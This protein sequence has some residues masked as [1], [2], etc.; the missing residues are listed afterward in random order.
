MFVIEQVVEEKDYSINERLKDVGQFRIQGPGCRFDVRCA[1]NFPEFNKLFIGVGSQVQIYDTDK[2]SVSWLSEPIAL[3]LKPKPVKDNKDNGNVT[4][5]SGRVRADLEPTNIEALDVAYM[6]SK[7]ILFVLRTDLCIEFHSFIS[8]AQFSS[9]TVASCGHW[10]FKQP[11]SKLLIRDVPHMTTRLFMLGNSNKI[12][13]WLIKVSE[14]SSLIDFT[15]LQTLEMHKDLVRD[16]LIINTRLY[17]FF[18][19]CGLDNKVILWDL[20]TL[21]FKCTRSGHTAGVQCLA[22]DG[23]SMLLAGGFDQTI[24][25]WDL[26]A[27]ITK[28]LFTLVGHKGLVTKVVALGDLN[29]ILSLDENGVMKYWDGDKHNPNDKEE[30]LID[31]VECPTDRLNTF[32]LFTN[33]GP[34]FNSAHGIIIAAQGHK[35]HIYRLTDEGYRESAPLS[36]LFSPSLLSIVSLH[37][38]DIIFWSGVDGSELFK[39]GKAFVAPGIS[40]ALQYMERF[41]TIHTCLT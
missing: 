35:Q 33:A 13:S 11:K 7:D 27:E 38:K 3:E 10:V 24:I 12:E 40:F 22:F 25:A 32:E 9:E 15:D 29:R 8:R 41:Q 37:S 28:P 4:A 23:Q 16:I 14:G 39:L 2:N 6:G 20:E 17:Q 19:S 34:G 30:R 36:V 21:K 31:S 5:T 18:V 1:K 26:D